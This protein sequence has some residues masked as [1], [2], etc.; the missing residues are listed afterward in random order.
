MYRYVLFDLDGTLTDPKE[1]I[2]RSVQYALEALGQP[3][4][5]LEKL[6]KFIG[7]PLL[8]QFMEHCGISRE[9]AEWMVEKYRERFRPI[10]VFENVLYPGVEEMLKA[11]KEQ[12]KVLCVASSKPEVFV[13]QV[14]EHFGILSYFTVIV[15]SELDGRRTKKAEVIEEVLRQLQIGEAE[16]K[17]CLMIGDRMHDIE[18]GREMGLS[19]LGVTFGYGGREELESHGA[20]YV[21]DTWEEL[22]RIV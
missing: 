14:L 7:P 9:Q 16:R 12:G 4:P 5:D 19:T 6:V 15:G 3:E 11:L 21:A 22:L 17:D 18:G 1:G 10:G 20:D 13:R 2:T 8:E